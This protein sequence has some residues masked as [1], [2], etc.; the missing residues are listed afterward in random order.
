[1]KRKVKLNEAVLE[2]RGSLPASSTWPGFLLGKIE[3]QARATNSVNLDIEIPETDT[4]LDNLER[5]GLLTVAGPG[6]L[7]RA[8]LGLLH[9]LQR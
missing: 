1:M 6:L 5:R 9:L 8:R 7:R 3:A 4:L 2:G